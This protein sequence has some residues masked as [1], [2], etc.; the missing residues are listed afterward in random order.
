MNNCKG[1]YVQPQIIVQHFN[2]YSV[3]SASGFDVKEADFFIG[4]PFAK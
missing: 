1:N 4:N 2:N 3:L